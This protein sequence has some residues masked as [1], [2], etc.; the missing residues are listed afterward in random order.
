MPAPVIA[1]ARLLADDFCTK[2]SITPQSLLSKTVAVEN[3]RYNSRVTDGRQRLLRFACTSL[4]TLRFL[5]RGRLTRYRSTITPIRH[6]YDARTAIEEIDTIFD[7]KKIHNTDQKVAAEYGNFY[8]RMNLTYRKMHVSLPST[9]SGSFVLGMGGD[10]VSRDVCAAYSQQPIS[11]ARS[12]HGVEPGGFF[13]CAMRNSGAG[14]DDD[15]PRKFDVGGSGAATYSIPAAVPQSTP[16]MTAALGLS[17]TAIRPAT[18]SWAGRSRA[19]RRIARCP[20]ILAQDGVCGG[21]I[22]AA[23]D[24]FCPDGPRLIAIGRAFAREQLLVS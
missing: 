6:I 23:T 16:G 20:Q 7:R 15:T 5:T 1:Y 2:P 4:S 12:R 17:H 9:S 13:V 10:G 11:C 14:A 21:T 8:R 3:H 24:G 19:C 22:C 18:A